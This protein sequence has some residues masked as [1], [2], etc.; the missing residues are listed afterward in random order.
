MPLLRRRYQSSGL[1]SRRQIFFVLNGQPARVHRALL[2]P[3]R[4][5]LFDGLLE[6]IS[7]SLQIAIHR[8][9]TY[10]G[11]P[12]TT[13]DQVLDLKDNRVLAVPRNDKLI[14][15]G[16]SYSDLEG[17][18]PPLRR[19]RESSDSTNGN[20][21]GAP[22]DV[23][24]L[25]GQP[26]SNSIERPAKSTVPSATIVPQTLSRRRYVANLTQGSINPEP[27]LPE[28]A[29]PQI[30]EPAQTKLVRKKS[31]RQKRAIGAPPISNAMQALV[32]EQKVKK[33]E[34][35][36]GGAAPLAPAARNSASNTAD[37]DSGR[38]RSSNDFSGGATTATAFHEELDEED[39]AEDDEEVGDD[40]LEDED[41][42][43]YP[44]PPP[45]TLAE[46]EESRQLHVEP[47]TIIEEEPTKTPDVI[48]RPETKQSE[49]P[50]TKQSERPESIIDKLETRDGRPDSVKTQEIQAQMKEQEEMEELNEQVHDTPGDSN[51]Y[52]TDEE[53]AA[54]R[55]QAATRGYLA[56]KKYKVVKFQLSGSEPSPHDHRPGTPAP[57]ASESDTKSRQST[58]KSQ[59]G[60]EEEVLEAES[61]NVEAK[62]EEVDQENFQNQHVEAKV[63]IIGLNH[64]SDEPGPSGIGDNDD[65]ELLKLSREPETPRELLRQAGPLQFKPEI[66]IIEPESDIEGNMHLDTTDPVTES[67]DSS[68]DEDE[69]DIVA[70][71]TKGPAEDSVNSYTVTVKLGNRWAADSETELYISMAG[72]L[73]ESA[74][75][76]MRQKYVNWLET[77]HPNYVQQASDTFQMQIECGFLGILRRLTIGHDT[78][79]YGAGIFIDR[80]I[81]TEDAANGRAYLFQCGKWMDSGQVDGKLERILRL[82]AYCNMES[83]PQAMRRVTHGRWEVILHSG[84]ERGNGGTTSNLRLVGF[85]TRGSSELLVPNETELREVPAKT[86]VQCYFKGIGELLKLRVEIDG[87]GESPDYFLDEVVLRD[88]DTQDRCVISCGKWL[89]WQSTKKGDQ[90]FREFLTFHLGNEPL[91]VISYD[92]K[93]RVHMQDLRFIK[94][95]IR[96]E[97]V[98]DIGETGL[99]SV[100]LNTA[101]DRGGK[102]E[103]QFKVEAVSVG[104]VNSAR[105]YTE[106]SDAGEQLYE[107]FATLQRIWDKY[108]GPELAQTINGTTGNDWITGSMY[109]REGAH[110]PYRYVLGGSKIKPRK[111]D[112]QPYIKELKRSALEG[113]STRVSKKKT[114]KL[115]PPSWL[116]SM[117]LGPESRL[118][119]IASLC[120]TKDTGQ[121]TAISEAP[122]DNMVSF[123]LKDSDLGNICKVR[124]KTNPKS[125]LKLSEEEHAARM[126]NPMVFIRKMRLVDNVNGDE[127][128]FPSA[129]VEMNTDSIVEFPAFWPDLPPQPNILYEAEVV[130]GMSNIA[131]NV[132][133]WLNIYGEYGDVSYR[134]LLMLA[135]PTEYELFS[136]DSTCT[137]EF[138]AVSIGVLKTA[139]IT[140]ECKDP[141]FMW[142]CN[143]LTIG[144]SLNGQ[145]YIFHFQ[146]PF[147][148]QNNRQNASV[149][150]ILENQL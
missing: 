98:G 85:G 14:L 106:P 27:D 36:N 117:S 12:V 38:P 17:P 93:L 72:D 133:V 4:P 83:I 82:T 132:P 145:A 47:P 68:G 97:I 103:V 110:V 121:M 71:R 33:E 11:E 32:N 147:T 48:E 66:E 78:V 56:R 19:P 20:V 95:V 105:L 130:T 139:E 102:M 15:H 57:P 101:T 26:Q 37:S 76:Y 149:T 122:S 16:R 50:E 92:G 3:T 34:E 63:E 114:D 80:I 84:D 118:L 73:K 126:R 67:E 62:P 150:S 127:I 134:R 52:G 1:L 22:T 58:A 129:D 69:D 107:G 96:L 109:I 119:P 113:M 111:N 51:D 18:L 81:I 13:M 55:I 116:L 10:D 24:T 40:D 123:Q 146:K 136:E 75:F 135:E 2:N 141:E 60:N 88:L 99:I 9:Y 5:P 90:P 29:F 86:L 41:S 137:F 128:R 59:E 42:D 142:E 112:E 44:E 8:L 91:P 30:T 28:K 49:R 104:K 70:K 6:E 54:I 45:E 61:E 74:K 87:T 100:D 23:S 131:P 108:G 138:E 148:A 89:R 77:E 53:R 39:I 79:G 46:L 7:R 115:L 140:V 144:G 31:E 21:V 25:L 120:G 124:L 35:S 43:D 65:P 125:L 94:P 143:Q 64:S